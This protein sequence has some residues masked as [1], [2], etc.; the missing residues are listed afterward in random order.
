MC[1]EVLSVM[2]NEEKEDLE[3]TVSL[4]AAATEATEEIS[5]DSQVRHLS[6]LHS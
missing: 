4:L 6:R 2:P 5:R 1:F 3:V